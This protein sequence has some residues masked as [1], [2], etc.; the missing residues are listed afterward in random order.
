VGFSKRKERRVY[1]RGEAS[2]KWQGGRLKLGRVQDAEKYYISEKRS[3]L[4]LPPDS[5][6]IHHASFCI[7]LI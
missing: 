2:E 4:S 1:V 5:T 6:C 3:T 7:S